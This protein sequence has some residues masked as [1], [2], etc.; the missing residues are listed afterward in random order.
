MVRRMLILRCMHKVGVWLLVSV[1][2]SLSVKAQAQAAPWELKKDKDGIYIYT[3][4]AADSKFNELRVVMDMPGNFAQLRSILQD[5]PHFKDWIYCTKSSALVQQINPNEWI[6]Y[7]EV[8]APWPMSNRDFYSYTKVWI[9]TVRDQLRISSRN[10]TT[11]PPKPG[12][13]RIPLLRA[14]WVVTR[15]NRMAMRVEYTLSWDPGGG[16]PAW[17]V[18]L[19]STTGPFQSFSQLKKRMSGG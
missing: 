17:I 14:E 6:Y 5:I 11:Y 8:S 16:I 1:S 12:L 2:L 10:V 7:T 18:N 13:V 19:F 3:R 15:I 9:D 4:K